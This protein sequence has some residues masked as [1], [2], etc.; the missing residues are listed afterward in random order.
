MLLRSC[1][2]RY[3]ESTAGASSFLL[4]ALLAS[5]SRVVKAPLGRV[6][7]LLIAGRLLTAFSE[8][9]A[10]LALVAIAV[11]EL[12]GVESGVVVAT[13]AAIGMLTGSFAGGAAD[14]TSPLRVLIVAAVAGTV[15]A[16]ALAV[17][18][19]VG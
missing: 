13:A 6:V 7:W 4:D 11:K 16:G 5:L 14:F 9:I 18:T 12:G 19:A 17:V 8:G 3:G 10:A 15:C 1:R 2:R